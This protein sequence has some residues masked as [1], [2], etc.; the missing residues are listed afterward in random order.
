[1]LRHTMWL[2]VA[3]RPYVGQSS[4]ALRQP[5]ARLLPQAAAKERHAHRHSTRESQQGKRE[6]V[7]LTSKGGDIPALSASCP[8]QR[9]RKKRQVSGCA[10]D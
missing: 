2:G 6:S 9:E 10:S 5:H 3:H 4:F 1:M 7:C 8:L